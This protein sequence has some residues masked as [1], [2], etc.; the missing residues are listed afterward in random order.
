MRVAPNSVA[1]IDVHTDRL[2][3][4][5]AVGARPS[6]IAFGSGSLWVANL[7][8][9]TISRVDPRTLQTLLSIHVRGPPTGIAATAAGCG[10]S[11]RTEPVRE[12]ASSVFVDRIDPEFNTPISRACGLAMSIP[13]GPGPSRREATRSGSRR[14]PGC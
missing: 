5:V 13:S 10:S 11:N 14:P 12:P 7:D 2:V 3:G 6:A 4:A 8:D 9:Q 1:V